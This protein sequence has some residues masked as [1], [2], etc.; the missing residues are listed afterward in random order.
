MTTL[1]APWKSG[2]LGAYYYA[3]LP[4]RWWS[5]KQAARAG[6]APVM[7]IYYHRVADRTPNGWTISNSRFRCQIDWLEANFDLV[8]LDEVQ[9]RVRKGNDRAAVSIT[10][11]DGYAENCEHALPLL[12]S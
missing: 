7:V 11:D 10:F 9:R 5:N 6:M 3:T 4:G 8:S 1:R 2:L 12:I